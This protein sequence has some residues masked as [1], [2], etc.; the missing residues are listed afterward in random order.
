MYDQIIIKNL[1]KEGMDIRENFYMN[2]HLK[3]DL[4][5]VWNS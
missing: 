1:K 4:R 5:M 2:F 3:E